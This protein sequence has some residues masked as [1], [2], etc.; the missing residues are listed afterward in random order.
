MAH[1]PRLTGSQEGALAFDRHLAV[2]ANAGTGKTMV[3]VHRFV[4]ILLESPASLNSIVAITFTDKAA[5]ELRARIGAHVRE[6]MLSA[7]SP[8]ER[9]ILAGVRDRL[10]GAAIGTIHSFCAQLLREFPVEANVDAGFTVLKGIDQRMFIEEALASAFDEIL[11]RQDHVREEFLRTVRMLGRGSVYHTLTLFLRKREQLNRLLEGPLHPER[12]DAEILDAW[13][14]ATREHL[15]GTLDHPDFARGLDTIRRI[16]NG[17]KAPEACRR[18]DAFLT[19][20]GF[21]ERVDE[22]AQ[23]LGVLL[24][25]EGT[26][27]KDVI[28]RDKFNHDLA[29][30]H[31]ALRMASGVLADFGGTGGK[32]TSA[33]RTLLRILRVLANAYR[34][35]E[36]RYDLAKSDAGQLDFDDLQFRTRDLLRT[37]GIGPRL[38]EKFRYLMIDEFQDTNY[39]QYDIVRLLMSHFD[40]ANLFIVGDPK[41]SIYGFRN[42]EAEIFCAAKRDMTRSGEGEEIVL[43]ESFRL[44]P[45]IADFTNRIFSGLMRETESQFDFP[46]SPLI[47]ARNGQGDGTIELLLLRPRAGSGNG[48]NLNPLPEARMLAQRLAELSRN[49]TMVQPSPDTPPR[50]F[51]F[52]DAAILVRDRRRVRE[53]EQ[54]MREY[55]VPALLSGGT[56]F[57]QTQ[58]I[59]DFINYL[60]FLLNTDDDLALAGILRS[61]FFAISDA[62]LFEVSRKRGNGSFW[63]CF[64]R[65]AAGPDSSVPLRRAAEV[66]QGDLQHVNRIPIPALIQRIFRS[67]GWHGTV[68]G[69][70]TGSQ[71]NANMNKLLAVAREFEAKGFLTL[72]DFVERISA[73][74]DEE[75]REGQ[76]PIEEQEDAV[77]I[78]TI[79]AAKGLEFPVVALPFLDEG[80][81][82][83]SSPFIDPAVGIG[84]MV[85]EEAN[86]DVEA[87][88]TIYHTLKQRNKLRS[89]AEEKRIL[90]VAITRARDILLLSGS[91]ELH[92]RQLSALAWIS[93]RLGIDLREAATGALDLGEH[94]LHI[95]DRSDGEDRLLTKDH[96]LFLRITTAE[97]LSHVPPLTA[98]SGG[99]RITPRA[100]LS[101]LE[102]SRREEFFSATQLKTYL[103]CPAKFYIKNVLGLPEPE[104]RPHKF[105]ENA[106]PRDMITGDT[107]GSLTHDV[108]Q[109]L[110]PDLPAPAELA[111]TI[112]R[113]VYATAAIPPGERGEMITTVASHVEK[114]CSSRIGR[115]ILASSEYFTEYTLTTL[116]GDDFLTGTIDR[117]YRRT[118]DG[119]WAILDYKTDR[120][121]TSTLQERGT[122]YK[123]QM[124]VYALLVS[125]YFNQENVDAV[126][127]FLHH[128]EHPV[129][130]SFPVEGVAETE[131]EILDAIAEV[132]ARQ[133]S[134]NPTA[135]PNCG[136]FRDGHCLLTTH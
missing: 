20:T 61:P 104:R 107:V 98:Q 56:G 64:R 12:P 53:L 112:R 29:H 70:R 18:I 17:K 79:H 131:R 120:V 105:D 3:L 28:G 43:A 68:A 6:R 96:R 101:G 24:T 82:Y 103:E 71:N 86:F 33:D 27:R 102:G 75:E 55:N 62:E 109:H 35:A 48:E 130:F 47:S 36:E 94:R 116:L 76:A 133:F 114:F 119:K 73:L 90:Y 46:Y 97:E 60:T 40:R 65:T 11:G 110:T 74:A 52:S 38:R 10:A 45:S 26:L 134:Q 39:L 51:R 88:P 49:R 13:S 8:D 19:L 4:K 31:R 5:S 59:Y 113:R 41:Q 95:L 126:I 128:P 58:E 125:R 9:R 78:M 14:E 7:S 21:A 30:A 42:A 54:A 117:L 50:P 89:E 66:L 2:T 57:Y 32:V 81:R 37:S 83:D 23:L 80:F 63:E 132:K 67:T 22:A 106:E 108:L 72:Y 25:K 87:A 122:S 34:R 136:Y 123:T 69:L 129:H 92:A 135:C 16:A 84:L 121:T 124:A 93:D 111:E 118:S 91:A 1:R 127:I 77:H 99:G 115:E 15:R 85:K 44:L 100:L